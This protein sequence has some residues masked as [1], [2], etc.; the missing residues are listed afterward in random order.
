M[1]AVVAVAAAVAN[2]MTTLRL[3]PA[4]FDPTNQCR[5]HLHHLYHYDHL[6]LLWSRRLMPSRL[7]T[8][9]EGIAVRDRTTQPL[10]A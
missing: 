10:P 3:W 6:F 9:P 5:R 4:F 8:H 1:V 7:D 2:E